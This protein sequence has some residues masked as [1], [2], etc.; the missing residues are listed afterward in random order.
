MSVDDSETRVTHRDRPLFGRTALITGASGGIGGAIARRL[1]GA[2][3]RIAAH[4]HT[5][6]EAANALVT[7]LDGASGH[8]VV[9]GDLCDERAA[10]RVV[11]ETLEFVD[12]IDILVNNA[13]V[14]ERYPIMDTSY[15]VWSHGFERALEVNLTAPARLSYLVGRHMAARGSGRIVNIGSRGAFRGEPIAPGYGAAKA[16]LHALTQS[17]AVALAPHG[18]SV[19]AVAPGFVETAM[20]RPYLTGEM[21]EA[22]RH[23]SPL[24]RVARVGDVAYWVE[25]LARDEAGFATG[26]VID[27]NG[28]SHLR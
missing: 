23:Q 4:Y 19:F 7:E 8:M 2:G 16:G 27:V 10:R 26:A 20:A 18:V 25:C 3:A 24:G 21:A 5:G 28:A 22:I 6:R 15:E 17:L 14:Y 13:G 9:G 12:T 11:E 1:A